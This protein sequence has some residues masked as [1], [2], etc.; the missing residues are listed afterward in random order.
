MDI[1]GYGIILRN[2]NDVSDYLKLRLNRD[3][4]EK[5]GNLYVS[6]GEG[7]PE[8]KI[9]F[10]DS[11]VTEKDGIA[12]LLF[13][14]KMIL[15]K[16]NPLQFEGELPMMATQYESDRSMYC[17]H[18]VRLVEYLGYEVIIKDRE[19]GEYWRMVIDLDKDQS[20]RK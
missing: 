10:R 16:L 18:M 5:R 11:A 8:G 1:M 20:R 15:R 17:R 13:R 3:E 9:H 14:R 12:I 7:R 2:C 6:K 19:T 4:S